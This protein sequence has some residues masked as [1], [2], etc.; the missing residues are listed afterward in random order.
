[1]T[2]VKATDMIPRT[3]LL[4]L[5]V[6]I[7]TATHGNSNAQT[8]AEGSVTEPEYVDIFYA[9]DAGG[10]LLDLERATVTYR[11]KVNAVP[12]Y[13]SVKMIAK[14]KPLHAPV[15]V[16]GTANF[17][18]RG[19]EHVDPASVYELRLVRVA[20]S[21]REFVTTQGHGSIFTGAKMENLEEQAVPVRFEHQGA[22]SYRIVPESPLPRG[23]YALLVR[24]KPSELYCFG[25]D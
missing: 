1:M 14:F 11:S 23:E 2:E 20:K 9:L 21:H 7:V 17:I 15:R 19:H 8:I 3:C 18:V 22:N 10:K 12:G 6:V 5:V 13:A 25:V 24:G 4:F 16:L